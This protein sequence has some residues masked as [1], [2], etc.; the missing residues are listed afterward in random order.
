MLFPVVLGEPLSPFFYLERPVPLV[1]A[2][3]DFDCVELKAHPARDLV[4]GFF[5]RIAQVPQR[6]E[7]EDHAD[8]AFPFASSPA[9]GP[10]QLPLGDGVS[11]YLE[12]FRDRFLAPLKLTQQ[13]LHAVPCQSSG[14]GPVQI[15]PQQQYPLGVLGMVGVRCA[16]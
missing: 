2:H 5:P 12:S 4:Y 15:A 16:V 11:P 1:V 9:P 14:T 7:N 6:S 3:G 10:R 8:I 13:L